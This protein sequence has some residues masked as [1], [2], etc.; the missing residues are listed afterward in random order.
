MGYFVFVFDCQ[1]FEVMV[2][3]CFGECVGLVGQGVFCDV[4]VFDVFVV[5]FGIGCVLVV[6]EEFVVMGDD[7][8][9][10]L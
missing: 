8:V 5:V 7:F 6:G 4:E 10:V 9:Q 3:Y 2:C 1:D